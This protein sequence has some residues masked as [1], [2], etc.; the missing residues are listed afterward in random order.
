MVLSADKKHG[1]PL[2]VV[3]TKLDRGGI[4]VTTADFLEAV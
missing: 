4:M 1:R 3:R 2:P